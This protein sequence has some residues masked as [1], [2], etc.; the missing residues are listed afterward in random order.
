MCARSPNFEKGV[1]VGNSGLGN[2]E[3]NSLRNT[4]NLLFFRRHMPLPVEDIRRQ[5]PLLE[6][7]FGGSPV[8]YLDSAATAQKPEA[9][10]NAMMDFYTNNYAN[11]HRGMHVLAEEATVAFED[12]RRAVQ[13]FIGAAHAEEIIFTKSCTESIN[14]VAKSFGS[15]LEKGDTVILSEL[16]H[17][18]NIVPWLQLKKE[19]SIEL[20]WIP[21]LQ[22][23]T[24]DLNVYEELLKE[25]HV[26]LVCLTAQSNVTGVKPPLKKMIEQAHSAGAKVL[27]DAAQSIAHEKTHVLELDADFLAFSGHKLY[28]PT[29]IGI[30]YGKKHILSVMPPFLGGGMMIHEVYNDHFSPAD[31]PAKFEAGTQPIAEA[32]GLHAAIDWINQYSWGDIQAHEHNLIQKAYDQLSTIDGLTILGPTNPNDIHGCISFTIDGIHPHDLTDILGKRGICLR[33]GHH[34]AQILHR[35]LGINASTRLSVG[36]Y[37]TEEEINRAITA[38]KEMIPHLKK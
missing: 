2:V 20:R 9:V 26:K 29:G 4:V 15:I 21:V 30:L 5:F 34:C 31:L 7:L 8:T 38:I 37:N 12:A 18:S 6:R 23:G 17:H 35:T 36:I 1:G 11:P 28:G 3:R 25:K 33:A 16:E 13:T 32:V 14:L 22:D 10:L 24:L 19:K 27:V